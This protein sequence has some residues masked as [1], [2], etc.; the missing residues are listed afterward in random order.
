MS[1]EGAAGTVNRDIFEWWV[2]NKLCPVLGE[3]TKGESRSVVILDNASTHMSQK[4]IELISTINA[5]VVFT[6]PFS[7]DLNPIENYFSVYKK[8]LKR[9][10][11]AMTAN[12]KKVHWEALAT[13]DRNMGIRYFRRCGISGSNQLKTMEEK[14]KEEEEAMNIFA[15]MLIIDEEE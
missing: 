5:R 9:N 2:E 3:Y 8:Y 6:A 12:W 15:M 13:V 7:P 10:N 14:N 4:V 1:N 11:I